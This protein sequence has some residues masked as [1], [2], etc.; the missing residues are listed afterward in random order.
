MVVVVTE[1]VDD[2]ESVEVLSSGELVM[3]LVPSDVE[4]VC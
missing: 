4:P 3:G 1:P 2:G